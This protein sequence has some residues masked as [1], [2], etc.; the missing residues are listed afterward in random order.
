M[1]RSLLAVTARV[2]SCHRMIGLFL[3]R[4]AFCLAARVA[5]PL[6][7]TI[8]N[9]LLPLKQTNIKPSTKQNQCCQK[10]ADSATRYGYF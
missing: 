1:L 8:A 10:V 7:H 2:C 6:G 9:A 5:A 4:V 3:S